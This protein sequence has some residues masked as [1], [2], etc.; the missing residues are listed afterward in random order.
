MKET[1]WNYEVFWKE[2]IKQIQEEVSEQEFQM[3]FRN[4]EYLSSSDSQ[5]TVGVPS[6]FY[7]D[8]VSQRF[9]QR[10][11]DK[12]FE[13][14]GHRI[15]LVFQIQAKESAKSSP[16]GA[17]K[18][19]PAPAVKKSKRPHAQLNTEYNFERFVRGENND[20][21]YMAS[22]AIARNPGKAYNPC[23]IYGGV[24]L[25]KTHLL[26]AIGNSSY[27]EFDDI[28]ISPALPLTVISPAMPPAATSVLISPAMTSPPRDVPPP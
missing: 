20:F 27:Q 28:R 8:Q 15:A 4:M 21:A 11:E 18:T 19:K 24:G 5:I 26:Q 1:E 23:M 17:E 9:Q 14:S 6:T 2:T 25:G 12:L 13:L 10:I 3:W 7:K 22:Y 16:A